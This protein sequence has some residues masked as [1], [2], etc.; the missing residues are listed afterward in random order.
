MKLKDVPYTLIIV[1]KPVQQSSRVELDDNSACSL[2]RNPLGSKPGSRKENLSMMPMGQN[3]SSETNDNLEDA[4]NELIL[5][6]EDVVRFQIGEVFTHVPRE[7]VENRLETMKEETTKSLEKL[8]EE[9]D[10]VVAQMAE[11]KKILYGKF[12]D[13]INLEED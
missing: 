3:A 5:S 11:L 2:Q 1:Q 8:E 7:E 6:D 13:S 9:K 12:K 4:S 10:S